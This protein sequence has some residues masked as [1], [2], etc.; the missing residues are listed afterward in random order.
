MRQHRTAWDVS[1][2]PDAGNGGLGVIRWNNPS[3]V[4]CKAN[5]LKPEIAD[6]D[7]KLSHAWPT[8]RQITFGRLPDNA[9]WC[10]ARANL[11]APAHSRTA[12]RGP[13]PLSGA[14]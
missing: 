5:R 3:L 6:T 2:R 11:I 1:N 7:W 14:R 4:Q 9:F 13:L 8:T 12:R 10:P